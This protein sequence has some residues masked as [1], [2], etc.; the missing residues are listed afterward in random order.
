MVIFLG[1]SEHNLAQVFMNKAVHNDP[2]F[3]RAATLC[4]LSM[5]MVAFLV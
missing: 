4:R 2:L 5:S 3:V 1:L